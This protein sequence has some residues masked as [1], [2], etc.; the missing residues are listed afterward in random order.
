MLVMDEVLVCE[1]ERHHIHNPFAVVEGSLMG[2][3]RSAR[4][5]I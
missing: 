4:E 2:P 5:I 1:R 3:W